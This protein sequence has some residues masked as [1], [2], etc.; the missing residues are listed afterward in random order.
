MCH[1]RVS[2]CV[3]FP[4]AFHDLLYTYTPVQKYTSDYDTYKS[5]LGLE[6][7]A[8]NAYFL[9]ILPSNFDKSLSDY[10]E[11]CVWYEY[12]I[13]LTCLIIVEFH[14][15]ELVEEQTF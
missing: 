9:I 2:N 10:S 5:K 7:N 4:R 11:S 12:I 14:L 6:R 8:I 13:I 1:N 15:S 3:R